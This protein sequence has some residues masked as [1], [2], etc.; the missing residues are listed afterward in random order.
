MNVNKIF[1]LYLL[2]GLLVMSSKG[3]GSLSNDL[4]VKAAPSAKDLI[5]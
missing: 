4:S 2:Q 5:Q 3:H 1:K